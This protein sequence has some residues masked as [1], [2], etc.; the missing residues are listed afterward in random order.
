MGVIL[1]NNAVSRLSASL[2][3]GA[4]TLSVVSGE[5]AKFP[6]P[7]GGDWFPLTL[8]KASGVLEIMHCTTRSGDVLTVARAQEGT[9][10]QA[11]TAGD[12]VELRITAETLNI[13]L[14]GSTAV[15]LF[16]GIELVGATPFLD[17]RYGSSPTDYTARLIADA[18]NSLTV[19]SNG[20]PGGLAKFTET[21][22]VS[23]K[24]IFAEAGLT[25]RNG[26]LRAR[27]GAAGAFTDYGHEGTVSVYNPVGTLLQSGV[28]WHGGNFNPA[29]KISGNNCDSAGFAG[30]DPYMRRTSDSLV[31]LLQPKLGFSPVQQGTGVGQGNNAVK[32]GYNAGAGRLALTVDNTDFGFVTTD[33]RIMPVSAAQGTGAIGTYAFCYTAVAANP[34]DLVAGSNLLLGHAGGQGSTPLSGTWRTM[35]AVPAGGRTLFLRAV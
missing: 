2:A 25:S 3:I 30:S 27:N 17:F 34:G 14:G 32:L 15:P 1:A 22:F 9:A 8:V 11:F 4:T 33:D 28:L 10:A 19:S 23:Y 7:T 35:G 6:T 12:R 18:D 31:F 5:G 24:P 29:T 16:G 20:T 26:S 21:G 13:V